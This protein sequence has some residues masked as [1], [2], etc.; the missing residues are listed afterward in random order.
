M[1]DTSHNFMA[2]RSSDFI[3]IYDWMGAEGGLGLKPTELRVYALIYSFSGD[4]TQG[5]PYFGSIDYTAARLGISKSSAK[6]AMRALVEAGLVVIYGT[7]D[8]GVGRPR[9]IYIADPA[10]AG[11]AI[12]EFDAYWA[13]HGRAL[14]RTLDASSFTLAMAP[15][16]ESAP[17]STDDTQAQLAVLDSV[18]APSTGSDQG[19]QELGQKLAKLSG[20]K[21]ENHVENDVDNRELGQNPAE[22]PGELGQFLAPITKG[23]KKTN[24]PTSESPMAVSADADAGR[25]DG[26]DA[27]AESLGFDR[28]VA[29][30]E[31]RNHLTTEDGLAKTRAA[32][33]AVIDAGFA[34]E[35]VCCAFE[36]VVAAQRRANTPLRYRKQLLR[37]LR[38]D[39]AG[40]CRARRARAGADA[41]RHRPPEALERADPAEAA[42]E[43][44]EQRDPVYAQMAAEYRRAMAEAC[45]A[46][47]TP[48]ADAAAARRH[49]EGIRQRNERYASERLGAA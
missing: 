20:D 29:A 49:A 16:R 37:W 47:C 6:S 46:A 18:E 11:R 19:E 28:L 23:Y 9:P 4:V 17:I 38:C 35:E 30:A 8:G 5:K 31:N 26:I 33:H 12:D 10:R 24:Q 3:A 2:L 14:E 41:A 42:K 43:E 27:M 36:A 13:E 45:K 21:V 39:A 40:A 32:Y 15:A 44:L 22:L 25:T 34:A 7:L 48:G 1:A